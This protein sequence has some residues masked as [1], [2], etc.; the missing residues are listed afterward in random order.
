MPVTGF[1]TQLRASGLRAM[2]DPKCCEAIAM[3]VFTYGSL[4]FVP[5][6]S[7]VVTGA[8][9]SACAWLPGYQRCCVAGEVYPALIPATA[10]ASVEGRLYFDI[11]DADLQR[12][13]QFEGQY[14]QRQPVTC[15]L[16]DNTAAA[17][18]VYV[19][20]SEYRHLVD[21]SD[22][23]AEKFAE[24]GIHAFLAQYDGFN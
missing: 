10:A 14:Y 21:L 5:V 4:M 12:L 19:F 15:R 16:E 13:D 24:E 2:L 9:R 8:Y 18:Q 1:P 23:D 7:K 11:G 22:W 20:R 17:A 3:H 6:W